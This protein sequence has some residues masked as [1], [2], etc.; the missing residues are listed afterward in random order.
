VYADRTGY[1]PVELLIDKM[2]FKKEPPVRNQM[3]SLDPIT[4]ANGDA[5]DKESAKW[6]RR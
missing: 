5:F 2:V 3:Q 4:K 1:R 6:Y